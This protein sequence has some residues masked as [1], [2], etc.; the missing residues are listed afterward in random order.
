MN[1]KSI[2]IISGKRFFLQKTIVQS[3]LITMSKQS[4]TVPEK[5]MLY[6]IQGEFWRLNRDIDMSH[7]LFLKFDRNFLLQA[8]RH[9]SQACETLQN[10]QYKFID[11]RNGKKYIAVKLIKHVDYDLKTREVE[12]Q[13][14]H[15]VLPYYFHLSRR[16]TQLALSTALECKSVYSQRLF[17]ICSMFAAGGLFSLNIEHL[18]KLFC[19]DRNNCTDDK[20]D[21]IWRVIEFPQTELFDLYNKNRSKLFFTF[22]EKADHIT[23]LVHQRNE[24]AR[25]SIGW[26]KMIA[27]LLAGILDYDQFVIDNILIN[28][29]AMY[30]MTDFSELFRELA[31][32]KIHVKSNLEQRTK[33]LQILYTHSIHP[34]QNKTQ[35]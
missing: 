19:V 20:N 22:F 26:A 35:F 18:K 28:Y 16:F 24:P 14:S 2:Y 8:D 6:I 34:N 1:K 10:L 21:L 9:I 23:F 31:A 12:I 4:W 15:K 17:E 5:K 32:V 11:I 33:I 30:T 25:S 3:N 29:S 7:D 27:V 13:I